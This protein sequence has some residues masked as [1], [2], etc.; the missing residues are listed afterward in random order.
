M[1]LNPKCMLVSWHAV[2]IYTVINDSKIPVDFVQTGRSVCPPKMD[3]AYRWV[4]VHLGPQSPRKPRSTWGEN[5]MERFHHWLVNDGLPNGLTITAMIGWSGWSI[6]MATRCKRW[7]GPKI[8]RDVTGNVFCWDICH[9]HSW[10]SGWTVESA[11]GVLAVDVVMQGCWWGCV[12]CVSLGRSHLEPFT[13]TKPARLC[14][15]LYN[16]HGMQGK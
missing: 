4:V 14:R 9:R 13:V 5:R 7:M 12:I 10:P 2:G 1:R 15:H 6:K 16:R 3:Y 11:T 8:C